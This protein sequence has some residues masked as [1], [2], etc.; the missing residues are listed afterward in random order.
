MKAYTKPLS[1]LEKSWL[2]LRI[3]NK[4]SK[5][6]AKSWNK[7]NCRDEIKRSSQRNLCW[8]KQNKTRLELNW[9]KGK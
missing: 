8:A 3:K 1:D 4:V 5:G 9:F 2:K 6:Q 7:Q